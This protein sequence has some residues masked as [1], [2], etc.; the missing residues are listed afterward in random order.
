MK[1]LYLT[2]HRLIYYKLYVYF[3]QRGFIK[4]IKS[5]SKLI[6]N[7]LMLFVWIFY[8]SKNPEKKNFYSLNKNIKQKHWL[9]FLSRNQH[10]R[11]ISEGSCDT[12]DAENSAL[13]TAINYILKCIQIEKGYFKE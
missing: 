3:I 13:I 12:D 2:P 6:C 8:S 4:L 10:I 11:M 5:V 1:S 9:C 7:V